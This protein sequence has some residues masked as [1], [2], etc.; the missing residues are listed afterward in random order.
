MALITNKNKPKV[1]NVTGNVKITNI[2][3][4]KR[5]SN[6]KTTATITAVAKLAT[7]TPDKRLAINKTRTAV[8]RSL[9]NN[10]IV[11]IFKLI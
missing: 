4:I 11:F 6:P 5:F 7:C 8:T 9:S 2:G 10:F 1:I 3:F